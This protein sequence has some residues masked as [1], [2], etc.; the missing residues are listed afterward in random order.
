[1]SRAAAA[2]FTAAAAP[3]LFT[4]L[5]LLTYNEKYNGGYHKQQHD[6]RQIIRESGNHGYYP[7][8]LIRFC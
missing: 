6:R 5:K 4:I 8:F 3:P 7:L 1:M 2:S